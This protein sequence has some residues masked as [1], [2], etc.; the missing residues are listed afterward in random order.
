MSLEDHHK[1]RDFSKTPKPK[2]EPYECHHNLYVIQK[3]AARKL[4]YDFRIEL[5]GVLKSWVIPKGPCLDPSI[6]RPAIHVEDHPIAY[7]HFEGVIPKGEYGAGTVLLWDRGSR[8][9]LAKNPAI[10]YQK[11]LLRFILKAKKLNG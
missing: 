9:P 1:K 5:N 6:K 3:H 11:G 10:A 8:I 2:G 7:G 4:H